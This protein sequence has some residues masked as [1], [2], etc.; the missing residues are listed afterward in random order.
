[1]QCTELHLH[2]AGIRYPKRSISPSKTFLLGSFTEINDG[3]RVSTSKKMHFV[4]LIRSTGFFVQF[5]AIVRHRLK[6]SA[7]RLFMRSCRHVFHLS[8]AC[9][10]C[11]A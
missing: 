11:P 9:N 8:K 1:M 3:N 5:P 6:F 10:I 4:I 2:V 7:S